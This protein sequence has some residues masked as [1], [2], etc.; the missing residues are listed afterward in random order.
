MKVSGGAD[1]TI[2]DYS[3]SAG[4]LKTTDANGT[5][6]PAVAGTDYLA[7]SGDGSSLTG[8]EK[9]ANKGATGGYV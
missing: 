8:V 5:L 1:R 4:L 2:V 6:A 7:P 9:T 3:G